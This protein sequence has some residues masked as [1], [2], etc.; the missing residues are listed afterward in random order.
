MKPRKILVLDDEPSVAA[1]YALALEHAGHHVTKCTSYED[2]RAHLKN[3]AP[4]ALL[5]DVRVGEF[6]GL[7]LA[8]FFRS[9]SPDGPLMIVSG[10]DDVVIRKEAERLGAAFLLKPVD[11]N[12]LTTFFETNTRVS[13][14]R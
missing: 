9:T 2:A 5:A 6:N 1:L 12:E 11:I 3:D 10:H 4:E 7:Q 13:A 14:K 8:L